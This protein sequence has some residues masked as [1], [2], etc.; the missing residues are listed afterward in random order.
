MDSNL[1]SE[2]QKIIALWM[3]VPLMTLFVAFEVF[4]TFFK[5]KTV[6][7]KTQLRIDIVIAVGK[8]ICET[9]TIYLTLAIHLWVWQFRIFE[10]SLPLILQIPL[11]LIVS[12]FVYYWIHRFG[13]KI[14]WIWAT[15]SVHHTVTQLNITASLRQGWTNL[16]SLTWLV[17]IPAIL[18][19]M[20]P[21]W[22]E[23]GLMVVIG[24]Q[25][26]VHTD[27]IGDLGWIEKY[28]QTPRLHQL[29]HSARIQHRDRNFSGI[30]MIW[31]HL[32]GTYL[33]NDQLSPMQ[34]GLEEGPQSRVSVTEILFGG[35]KELWNRIR[36]KAND[37][38]I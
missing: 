18:L 16:I 19:G 23:L 26:W 30:F 29:H 25:A 15:H 11:A 12:D 4:Q 24:Y 10:I 27:L 31:D 17:P 8:G 36:S 14:P 21:F 1:F 34:Y 33:Y 37:R 3:L 20:H 7:S 35:W 9:M 22:I 13:H 38:A 28:F 32:F 5:G 2:L 6:Y